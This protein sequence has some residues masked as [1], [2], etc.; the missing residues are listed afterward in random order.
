MVC[1]GCASLLPSVATLDLKSI[2]IKQCT[3]R[4]L[5]VLV[6]I[7]PMGLPWVSSSDTVPAKYGSDWNWSNKSDSVV[8]AEESGVYYVDNLILATIYDFIAGPG[9][10][11]SQEIQC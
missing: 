8:L 9:F 1:T 10:R 11:T 5:N 2:V 4:D 7:S 3:R 6:A